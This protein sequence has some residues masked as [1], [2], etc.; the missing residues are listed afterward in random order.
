MKSRWRAK[1]GMDIGEA[2]SCIYKFV[3]SSAKT[4]TILA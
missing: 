4:A 1:S 3:V 2:A